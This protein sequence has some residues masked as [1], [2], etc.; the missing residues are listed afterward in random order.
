MFK[1][2][3]SQYTLVVNLPTK[4]YFSK[5]ICFTDKTDG[6]YILK[7]KGVHFNAYYFLLYKSNVLFVKL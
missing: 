4:Q 1:L 6:L 5:T 7:K 3:A 2:N